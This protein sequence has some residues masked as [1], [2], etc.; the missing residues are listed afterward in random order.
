MNIIFKSLNIF[1]LIVIL[2]PINCFIFSVIIAVYNT[3][4]YLDDSI[5]SL[6]NQTIN[7]SNIQIILVN[8]GSSDN[9][10]EICL[11]YQKEYNKNIVYIKIKHSGVSKARNIGLDYAKGEF[12]NFLD[13]DDK[14][15]SEALMHVSIFL[16]ENKNVDIVAGRLLFFEAI[17]GY[18]PL[19]Y[20]FYKTRVVNLTREYNCIQLS[21]ASSFFRNSLIKEKRFAEDVFTGEDTIFINNILLL[22]PIMGLIREAIYYYRRRSDHTSAVQNQVNKVEFYFSQL[23][24]VGQYLLDKSTELY[25]KAVPFLQFYIGY[26]ALFRIISP[27]FKYLNKIDFREYCNILEDQLNQIEDKYILEQRFTSFKNKLFTLSKKHKRDL[28]YDIIFKNNSL[29]YSGYVIMNLKNN[30]NIIVWR[31]LEINDYILHLEG[32]ED[33]WMPRE[34]YFFYCKIGNKTFFPKYYIY[35]GYDYITMYGLIEKGRLVI[36]DIPIENTEEQTIKIF[37]SYLNNNIEIFPSLGSLTHIPN[38]K[39][40]YYSNGNYIIKIIE[41]RL[42]I[43]RYSQSLEKLFEKQYCMYLKNITKDNIIKLRSKNKSFLSFNKKNKQIWIINDK[44][45]CAGDNGEYFFRYLIYKNPKEIDFYFTII[46]DCF[47]YKRLKKIGNIL[48]LGSIRYLDIFLQSDKIISSVSD[49]WVTNP[50]GDEQKYIKDLFHFDTI[51]IQNGIIKDDLSNI[52]NRINKNFDLLLSSSKKEYKSFLSSQYGYSRNNV[53]LTGL[54]RYDNLVENMHKIKTEKLILI[55]PTWRNFIK[56]TRDL[57]TYKSIYSDKFKNTK[58]YKF[59]NDLINDEKLLLNMEKFNYTGI[60][61]LH[62]YFTEQSKDFFPNK[63]FSI[64]GKCNFQELLSRAS[65]LVTD[66]SSIFFDFAYLKKPIIYSQFDIDEYRKY[67]HPKGYFDYIKD[68]FGPVCW[69]IEC[70]VEKVIKTMTNKC[71]LKK[72]YIRKIEKFFAFLDQNNN[73]R[74]F[75]GIIKHYG[76]KIQKFDGNENFFFFPLIIIILFSIKKN[77]NKINIF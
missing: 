11:K 53:I 39:E 29:I 15:D 61:C 24:F 26:N 64:R 51:F 67:H 2:S 22:N 59:Y 60:L 27:A 75:N 30:G 1:V 36:F 41:R 45:D 19:D 43:Y 56:G 47:D 77:M 52:L 23:K 68:G 16:K 44:K 69:D 35:S 38:V 50:F 73:D 66:Y 20:K 17:N 28:R 33:F 34:T 7:F 3:G 65:L 57:I 74:I 13:A 31:F 71:I 70:T 48:D 5:G 63:Y 25:N 49:N 55:T 58:F 32:K 40:G 10:E 4:R 12:I 76:G 9:S 21:G 54:S 6:L 46:K 18:H 72:N 37:I 62:P 42:I 14:W 8:D